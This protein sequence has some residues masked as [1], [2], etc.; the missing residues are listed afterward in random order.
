[1]LRINEIKLPLDYEDE[2][3]DLKK[4]VARLLKIKSGDIKTLE[5]Y[6]KSVD[7]RKKNDIKF[8]FS[9]DITVDGDE[10]ALLMR[11][12]APRVQRVEKY[13]YTLPE[14]KRNIHS[15]DLLL[16]ASD[17]PECSLRLCLQEQA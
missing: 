4:E 16:S 12:S 10:E 17:L 2:Q 1:M 14:N 7:S 8:I 11:S 5:I 9:V 3:N 15:F 6:K 13:V